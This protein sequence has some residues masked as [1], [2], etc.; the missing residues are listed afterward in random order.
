[1][2][3]PRLYRRIYVLTSTISISES[4]SSFFIADVGEMD[5]RFI[6][7]RRVGLGSSFGMMPM[8]F[9]IATSERYS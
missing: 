2:S 3:Q 6:P 9:R 4:A 8:A 7:L 1:M 5:R